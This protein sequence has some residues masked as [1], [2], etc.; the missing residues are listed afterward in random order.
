MKNIIQTFILFIRINIIP[1]SGICLGAL[2]GY[3]HW[4]YWGCYWGT[5]PLSSE[6]WVN[7]AYGGLFV[8][9][10]VIGLFRKRS[11]YK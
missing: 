1:L 6:C 4:F 5:Y 11:N 3:L 10:I 2:L 9:Y 8:G 7:C